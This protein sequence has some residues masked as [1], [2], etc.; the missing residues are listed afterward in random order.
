MERG[1]HLRAAQTIAA[2]HA[3]IL[4]YSGNIMGDSG[5]GLIDADSRIQERMDELA[6]EREQRRRTAVLDPERQQQIESLRLALAQ[7]EQQAAAAAHP[8]RRQQLEL[9]VKDIE[10]QL[11]ELTAQG[12]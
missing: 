4:R 10:R 12:A 7:A 8:V 5:E 1:G 9:A 11:A 2:G 3:S 6:S